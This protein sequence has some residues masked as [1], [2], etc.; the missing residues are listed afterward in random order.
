MKIGDLIVDREGQL[1]IILTG[2]RLATA[3]RARVSY[4]DSGSEAYCEEYYLIDVQFPRYVE[5]LAADEVEWI[6]E[7]SSR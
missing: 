5:S 2:P 1:G 4:S 6:N 3:T 7:L